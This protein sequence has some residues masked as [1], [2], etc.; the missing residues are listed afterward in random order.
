MAVSVH[1]EW[2]QLEEVIVGTMNGAVVPRPGRDLHA[3]EYPGLR[4]IEEIPSGPYPQRVIDETNDELEALCELLTTL[5]V[6]VVRPE[7]RDSGIPFSTPDWS[8]EGFY[9]YCPRDGLLTVGRTILETPMVLRSRH[10]EARA[11]R[12][13]LQGYSDRGAIWASAPKPRLL[14]EMFDPSAEMGLRLANFEPAFDAAN[15]LKFGTDLLYLVSDSGNE[16]GWRWLQ[17]FLGDSY[18]VH[19]ARGIYASTHV[20]STLVPLR[21]GVLLTN[22]SRVTGDNLPAFLADWER[23]ECPELVDTGFTGT[24]PRASPWIGM[25][26]LMTAPGR[27]IVDRRQRGLMRVLERHDV[28]V[29]PSQ[30]THARTLGG[31]FHCVTLDVRRQGGLTTYR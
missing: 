31:G 2:D 19:P 21:P 25:N 23:I 27:A 7:P 30:L 8:T 3:V 24:V 26:I 4:N 17:N 10:Y 16:L 14:D 29:L 12:S 11:Y 9:D 15:V 22:P 13:I 20:D 1:T 28:E 18:T 5:G 6:K